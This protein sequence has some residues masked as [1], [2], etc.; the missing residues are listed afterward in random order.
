MIEAFSGASRKKKAFDA[1]K[2]ATEMAVNKLAKTPDIFWVFGAISYNQKELLEG[3]NSV[4]P[5]TPVIGCTTDGEISTPGLS[6]DSV[7]VLALASDQITFFTVAVD[8][9]SQ[10][11]FK[12]GIKVGNQFINT[13]VKYMQIFSD[14]LLGNGSK[15]VEGIQKVL[16][17]SIKI[18]G[19][20]AGDGSLFT[21]TYQYHNDKVLTDSIVSVAFEGDFLFGT[22]VSSGWTPVGM[23]KEVTK[24]IGNVVYELDGQPALEVYKKFLGKHASLLPAVGVEYPLGLLGPQGDVE[25]D[26]YF[27]CRATM[28]V[29]HEKGSITFAGDVPQG[30]MVKMT[31]GNELDVIEAAKDAA[32]RALDQL[33]KNESIRPKVAFLYSCMA[34]KI[35]LGSRTNEEILAIKEVIGKDFPMIGFYTYGEYSPVGKQHL[36]CL[37]NEVATITIIGE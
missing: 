16:G 30:A 3:V 5:G 1:G 20:T 37:H 31:M 19:G 29:D 34:R 11:S 27:L 4:I 33:K 36:S 9:L 22:G 18:A 25:E 32:Q 10:D 7:V 23:A 35:V 24:S 12:A 21:R 13:N 15:I 6:T 8:S 2:Q 26:G 14:G 17:K 28:G